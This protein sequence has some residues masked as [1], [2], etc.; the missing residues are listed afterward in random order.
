MCVRRRYR[1]RCWAA[2]AGTVGTLASAP[3]RRLATAWWTAGTSKLGL[4]CGWRSEGCGWRVVG[5]LRSAAGVRPAPFSGAIGGPSCY[6]ALKLPML[7]RLQL[8]VLTTFLTVACAGI[9]L[10]GTP[11]APERV[12]WNADWEFRYLALTDLREAGQLTDEQ[13]G[14]FSQMEDFRRSQAAIVER[15]DLA[16]LRA[17]GDAFAA[18]AESLHT[19]VPRTVGEAES[20]DAAIREAEQ[21]FR[22]AASRAERVRDGAGS[23]LQ[24]LLSL[25]T[26][27]GWSITL[28]S[29]YRARAAALASA[30]SR[31]CEDL[32]ALRIASAAY[33]ADLRR[34]DAAVAQIKLAGLSG[35]ISESDPAVAV[36]HEAVDAAGTAVER[37]TLAARSVGASVA[38]YYDCAGRMGPSA[39]V[40]LP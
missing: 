21:T 26:P 22:D 30:A 6:R 11:A 13:Q 36:V 2:V 23:F 33:S 18:V 8:L 24:T 20:V 34:A 10:A 40:L 31:V 4:A 28:L 15:R 29:T 14:R 1:G 32:R 35:P 27:S 5:E 37:E 17:E 38:A 19:S 25:P 9:A 3:T 39:G 7:Y 12:E 16:I